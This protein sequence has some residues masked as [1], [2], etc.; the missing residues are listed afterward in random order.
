[1]ITLN[2]LK[3]LEAD[4]RIKFKTECV[5]GEYLTIVCYM[6]ADD[7]LWNLPSA[8][9]CRGITFDSSG[10]CVC[11]P[12]HKFFNVNERESTQMSVLSFEN[13]ML[14]EKRD[15]SMVTPVLV[16]GKLHW[17]TKKSFYS[18]VAVTAAKFAPQNIQ[19][20]SLHLLTRGIT[21]IFEFT[22]PNFRI[23][24]DYGMYPEFVLLNARSIETG[25]YID[26]AE[27]ETL[28]KAYNVSVIKRF[29]I[30][31]VKAIDDLQ[32]VKNF[33]GYVVV[34]ANGLWTKAKS[35]WYLLNHRIMTDLRER[36]VAAAFI[37]EAL[38]DMKSMIVAEGK[39]LEP[40]LQ[41]ENRVVQQLEKIISDTDVLVNL[42]K[43][44]PSRKDAAIKYKN[45]EY[46]SLAIALYSGKEPDFKKFWK[47]KH[48][49]VDF[50]LS[51]IYN[52]SFSTE[53]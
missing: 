20:L 2:D 29:D 11:M 9:E 35:N 47:N 34:H 43:Q 3:H 50:N 53:E 16:N 41:I 38:D 39:S 17:K 23:V 15:G 26:R 21:P 10:K 13:A 36:D 40:I 52:P 6:I 12:F 18:D 8:I 7:K 44:E 46:F 45:D 25:E 42:M 33:E 28:C 24:I 27:L 32:S 1:M 4:P 48:L 37:D 30:D 19:R 5:D 51:V 31:P 49:R 14:L 22:H